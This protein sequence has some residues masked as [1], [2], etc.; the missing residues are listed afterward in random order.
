MGKHCRT[1][2]TVIDN[3][4]LDMVST[5]TEFDLI[6]MYDNANDTDSPFQYNVTHCSYYE[7]PDFQRY[8]QANGMKEQIS[9]FHLNCRGLSA[10]WNQFHELIYNLSSEVCFR[11]T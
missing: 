9:L 6:A 11:L 7:T 1:T 8:N 3:I 4:T 2:L 5:S 10:N